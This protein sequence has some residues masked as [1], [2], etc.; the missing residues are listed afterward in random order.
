MLPRTPPKNLPQKLRTFVSEFAHFRQPGSR[1]RLGRF[2]ELMAGGMAAANAGN[3]YRVFWEEP[4]SVPNGPAPFSLWS[5]LSLPPPGYVQV[6]EPEF[7][8]SFA[9][10]ASPCGPMHRLGSAAV[11]SRSTVVFGDEPSAADGI[12]RDAFSIC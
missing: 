6:R 12:A 4:E 10:G 1:G 3:E 8:Q 2:V 9:H 5:A 11:D 7:L